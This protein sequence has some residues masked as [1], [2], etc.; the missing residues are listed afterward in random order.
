MY[1]F[2]IMADSACD[3]PSEV[4]EKYDIDIVP[5][6]VTFDGEHYLS[7]GTEIQAAQM[8]E[9][10]SKQNVFPK[11]SQPNVA[12]FMK[13]FTPY[14]EQNIDI[15]YINLTSKFSGSFVSASNAKNLLMEKFPNAKIEIIDSEL[16]TFVQGMLV[17]EAIKMRD[18][19]YSFEQTTEKVQLLKATAKAYITVDSLEYLQK[20][21]RI[22]KTQALAG[23]ILNIK[24]IITLDTGELLPQSKVRGRKKAIAKIIELVCGDIKGKEEQ[25]NFAIVHSECLGEAEELRKELLSDHG[26]H[27]AYEPCAL[28][29]IIG[30]HIGPS[31]LAIAYIRK[32]EALN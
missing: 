11:T 15:L 30:S 12:D 7:D 25:Y 23:S 9:A 19:G 3:L 6:Y 24:P 28:G 13:V 22:G 10:M 8:F 17:I 27:L 31:V 14:L 26:I 18:A 5:Y 16:A 29:C 20:G 2:K 32:Y 1:S 21:G 4:T